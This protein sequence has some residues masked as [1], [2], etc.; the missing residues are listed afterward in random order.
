MGCYGSRQGNP[1]A[2][3]LPAEAPQ[4]LPMKLT[5]DVKLEEEVARSESERKVHFS[6]RV[7]ERD[8]V[9]SVS[10][11]QDLTAK[12]SEKVYCCC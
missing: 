6:S 4:K 8:A 7:S 3:K 10:I 5:E 9:L 2:H 12:A 11:E 1:G